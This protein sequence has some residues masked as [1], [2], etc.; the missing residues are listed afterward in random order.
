[1]GEYGVRPSHS[2]SIRESAEPAADERFPT[3]PQG[4][5]GRY[6]GLDSCGRAPGGGCFV[7]IPKGSPSGD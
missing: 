2:G 6:A 7:R 5:A 4:R 1:M 3:H